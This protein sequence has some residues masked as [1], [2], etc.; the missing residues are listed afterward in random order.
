MTD[1]AREELLTGLV[2]DAMSL[3]LHD[4]DEAD[5]GFRYQRDTLRQRFAKRLGKAATIAVAPPLP[6]REEIARIIDPTAHHLRDELAK[7]ESIGFPELKSAELLADKQIEIALT[8]ADAILALREPGPLGWQLS[9]DAKNRIA[10]ID[11]NRRNAALNADKIVAG[12]SS[13]GAEA[14]ETS[15]DEMIIIQIAMKALRH[16][17]GYSPVSRI[18]PVMIARDTIKKIET[19]TFE[20]AESLDLGAEATSPPAQAAGKR[21][22]AFI[23]ESP[24]YG[25]ELYLSETAAQEHALKWECEYQ[26]L[27][28]RDGTPL[29]ETP[30][31][32][33][34]L[35]EALRSI[36]IY[37][38]DTLSGRKDGPDDRDW[39]RQAVIEMVR[40]ADEALS[41]EAPDAG[42][43][44]S[45]ALADI[46]AERQ[47]QISVEGWSLDHDDSHDKCEMA[48]AAACYAIAPSPVGI[49]REWVMPVAP[50]NW[51]WHDSWWKPGFYRHNLIKAVALLLAEI[52][53]WDR[54][55][56][57][58]NAA[59]QIE[60]ER[61]K[62][63]AGTTDGERS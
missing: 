7:E 50:S 46:V 63:A 58:R 1:S 25:T 53:R 26:G 22:R 61:I 62:A 14:A 17:A 35:V 12:V 4:S 49:E 16:I 32:R 6:D 43:G 2:N 10:E 36:I 55:L 31:N 23:V 37:G 39:Q 59:N 9:D 28:V 52:E 33:D 54:L 57:R 56:A 15:R 21:P 60:I 11:D 48:V 18:Q 47:R 5:E 19:V 44:S 3:T 45:S 34:A 20:G 30:T 29:V 41:Q 51:P 40:R 8:K 27:Y 38:R 13:V 24:Q 42:V